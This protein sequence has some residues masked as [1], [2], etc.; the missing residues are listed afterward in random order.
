LTKESYSDLICHLVSDGYVNLIPYKT[1][2]LVLWWDYVGVGQ[3][4][5]INTFNHP[6]SFMEPN[7][8]MNYRD[9]KDEDYCNVW[10]RQQL[11]EYLKC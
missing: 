5:E 3:Y 7:A 6:H 8:W 4:G 9:V 2:D 1:F 11:E 10:N